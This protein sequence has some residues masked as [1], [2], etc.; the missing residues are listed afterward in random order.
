[1]IL[2]LT[3]KE[4]FT[5]SNSCPHCERMASEIKRLQLMQTQ[6]EEYYD[7]DVRELKVSYQRSIMDMKTQM[8]N[9]YNEEQCIV[10][11]GIGETIS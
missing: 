7:R 9:L 8:E 3:W 6:Y 2:H 5:T 4:Y 1:M 11:L 10:M